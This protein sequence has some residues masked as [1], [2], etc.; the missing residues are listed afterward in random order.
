MA[1]ADR[2]CRRIGIP[3]SF[4]TL[5]VGAAG[6]W[7]NAST[8]DVTVG[9]GGVTNNGMILLDGGGGGCGTATTDILIRSS[10]AGV[11]RPW[12]G[13]GA[14]TVDDVDVMDQAGTAP[15]TVRSGIDSG[16]NGANWTF[17]ASCAGAGGGG[18]SS[19]DG[20]CSCSSIGSGA[21]LS[22]GAA[23]GAALLA[24]LALL[25]RR[26]QGRPAPERKRLR[27]F[28]TPERA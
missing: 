24:G 1:G 11:Q 4:N 28:A 7:T 15:I 22:W 17:T 20:G 26:V 10:A 8:G 21:G 6:T 16:N 27:A 5:T 12:N 25:L 2:G 13:A 14:F 23:L 9:A 18:S 3:P 19:D